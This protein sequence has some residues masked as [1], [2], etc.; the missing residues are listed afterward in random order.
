[1]RAKVLLGCGAFAG[2]GVLASQSGV[3]AL[4]G[5]CTP[6]TGP[7]V[8]VGDLDGIQ[9]WG[10][11][12]NITAYSIATNSCNI[13]D[14][15]L[16]WFDSTN[17]HPVIAQHLYRLMN[18][19]LEQLGISWVKHGFGALAENFCCTC[20]DP[21]TFDVL[22]VGCSDPYT[23]GLNGDQNG[24]FGIA[25]LGPRSEINASTGVFPFPY[26]FQGVSG[27][28][29]Y[30]RLQVH[31]DDLDPAGNIGARYFVEG[32]YVTPHDAAAGNGT[33][34]ASYREVLVGTFSGG[35]WELNLTNATRAQAPA[36]QAWQDIDPTVGIEHVDVAGDGRFTLGHLCS[37]NGDGTWHYEYALYNMNSH[38][39]AR[40]FT[41]PIAASVNVTNIGFHDVDHHSGEPY[42]G[43]DWSATLAGGELAWSTQT[44]A[45]NENANA[46]R[47]GTLYNFRFDADTPPASVS[48]T[49][50]LFRPAA[51]G[52]VTMSACGPQAPQLPADVNGDG[53]VNVLD[54]IE[55][56]LCFGQPA[57]PPCDAADIVED[58][59][60]NVLDLI[61][62]LLAFGTTLP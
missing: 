47:W 7:D 29:I 20:Q 19:R 13:G 58:G 32:H 60:I 2:L 57:D 26:G 49:V 23:T 42:D 54:L 53:A 12:G 48:V 14:E 15:P 28:A 8:I 4:G 11:V 36:I 59:V 50:E 3:T 17:Q 1:M 44:F 39:N 18:G 27:D 52:T 55:L 40:S 34:N 5:I 62:L 51:F 24:F 22:G 33:N 45:E 31:N 25:G 46:L 6:S 38:S 61:E 37:D 56:L 16:P 10:T 35:G 21:G 43:T 41:V 9:K 30:K